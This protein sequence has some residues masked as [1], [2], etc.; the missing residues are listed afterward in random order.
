MERNSS[1]VITINNNEK[2]NNT[3]YRYPPQH[4]DIKQTDSGLTEYDGDNVH[5]IEEEY[6]LSSSSPQ[7]KKLDPGATTA[8]KT[9]K[10]RIFYHRYRKYIQ[11]VLHLSRL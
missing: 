8:L 4:H 6:A 1:I 7:L 2:D 11:Y 10:I 5:N 3:V 9:S